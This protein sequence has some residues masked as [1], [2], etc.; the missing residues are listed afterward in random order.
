MV[1]LMPAT[2][3]SLRVVFTTGILVAAC[4]GDD[5]IAGSESGTGSS[6]DLTG[7]TTASTT[8]TSADATEGTSGSETGTS[9]TGTTTWTSGA[10]P[11]GDP[12]TGEPETTGPACPPEDP[13]CQVPPED[14]EPVD[15]P[16][17]IPSPLPGVYDDL[18]EAPPDG[19]VRAS[20]GFP[21]RNRAQLEERVDQI[22]DRSHPDFG[23]FMTVAEWMADHAPPAADVELVK[24]WLGTENLEV[25]FETSNRLVVAFQGTAADFN[26]AFQTTLHVCMRKNPQ[27]GNPPFPVY[28]TLD[29]FTVPKF[30]ADR[31][32]GLMTADMP[33]PTGELSP[34]N[35]N[36]EADPPGDFA[37]G[38]PDIAKAY[39]LKKLFDQGYTGEGATLGI[40][41]AGTIHWNDLLIY[42]LSF[43]I[44]RE[45]PE[46]IQMM[47]PVA[48]KIS[49]TILDTQWG[50]SMA[51]GAKVK[52]Y[53]GPDARNTA[54]LYTFTEAIA[55]NEMDV[56][57]TSFAHR[58][59]S[60]PK[61]IRHQYDEAALQAAAYG[62]TVLCASGDSAQTD[63]PCSSP[64]VL[65][66]GGTEMYI[67]NQG[68]VVW[69]EAWELSGSGVTHSFDKPWWQD[70][71]CP[72]ELRG[73]TDVSLNSSPYT[74]LWMRRYGKWEAYGGTSFASPAFAAMLAVIVGK[75]LSE[76]KGR[77][78]FIH[79]TLY[80]DPEV[81]AAF[82]DITHGKTEFHDAEVG[83]DYPTGW[84]V[85]IVD[86]LEAALP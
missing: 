41:G 48:I 53:E 16:D 6:G 23:K 83:W 55:R 36:I 14:K 76:G 22:S 12:T 32:N 18:G 65:C 72:G 67:D 39:G 59:D 8:S 5:P 71:I 64:Y 74:P 56:F 25:T 57:T 20:I 1:R 37:Y 17:G 42:W 7:L 50:S 31:T 21:T 66:V 43:G 28:C 2:P 70:G 40:A 62:I 80:D 61:A 51:P 10:G 19:V 77:L 11:T 26:R 13:L 63:I 60:E 58:E 38:P 68:E 24:A 81:Q 82:R 9:S 86:K 3:R 84:G 35:P 46:R 30:V 54:L 15:K 44:E 29:T 49:E 78:G 75:R 45:V 69:E 79:P 47:E 85:P 33:A 52:I 27:A 73:V 4:T 34:E